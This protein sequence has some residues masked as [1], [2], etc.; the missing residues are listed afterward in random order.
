MHMLS[1]NT[2]LPVLIPAAHQAPE[3]AADLTDTGADVPGIS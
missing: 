2:E 3:E 1:G